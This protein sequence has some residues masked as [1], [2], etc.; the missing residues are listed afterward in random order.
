M[1]TAEWGGTGGKPLEAGIVVEEPDI[2]IGSGVSSKAM[3]KRTGRGGA[4]A[5]GFPPGGDAPPPPSITDLARQFG[6]D[7]MGAS[8]MGAPQNLLYGS[9]GG[10]GGAGG[11]VGG[12]PLPPWQR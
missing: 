9:G 11:P 2:E 10:H 5:R 12:P 1:V 3:S 6:Q 7:G 4:S 8:S